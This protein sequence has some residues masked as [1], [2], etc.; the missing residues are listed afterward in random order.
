MTDK[1]L[2][3]FIVDDEPNIIDVMRILLESD[4]HHVDATTSSEN[5]FNLILASTPDCIL[6]DIMMPGMD[7]FELC[8]KLRREV[9]LS[10][11]KIIFVSAKAFDADKKTASSCGGDGFIVKPFNTETFSEQIIEIV[12][13][14]FKLNYWG[15]RGTLPVPGKGSLRYGGNTSCISIELPKSCYLIFDAG[16]GI[17]VLSDHL[18]SS[19]RLNI[20]AKIFL[21]HPHW[22]HINALPFFLPLYIQG[23]K[24]DIMGCPQAEIPVKDLISAQMDGVYFPIEINKFA[25]HVNFRDLRE[26]SIKIGDINIHTFLLNHPGNCLGYRIE[27]HNRSICYITDNELPFETSTHF[28]PFYQKRLTLFIEKTDILIIDTTYMDD[29]YK[30]KE[31]WGHSCVSQVVKLAHH[32]K[33]KSLHLFHH[34]PEQNDDAIDLKLKTAQNLLQ[35]M[36]SETQCFAPKETDAFEI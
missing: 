24:F 21:S 28:D 25:A 10:D 36:Q 8:K 11:C 5:A 1:K 9:T 23:N 33:V 34:D 19:K 30:T 22:D 16:T 17:K 6:L 15:V 3:F 14:K 4:H 2:K 18:K 12:K 27:Y 31:L 35:E 20:D 13:D 26:E 7:G 29:E 32:A